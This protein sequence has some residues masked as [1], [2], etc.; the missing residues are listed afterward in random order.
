MAGASDAYSCSHAHSPPARA[1]SR[2]SSNSGELDPEEEAAI[3]ALRA[4]GEAESVIQRQ[5]WRVVLV[6]VELHP[7]AAALARPRER[8]LDQRRPEPRPPGLLTHEQV[9]QPAVRRG[10]PHAEPVTQLADRRRR[11]VVVDGG[12]QE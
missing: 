5:R 3:V 10:G 8:R 2:T 12:E 9:L 6:G 1:A 7:P 11:R 4:L